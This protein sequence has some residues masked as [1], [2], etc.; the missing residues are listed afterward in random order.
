MRKLERVK[1]T[2]RFSLCSSSRRGLRRHRHM[3]RKAPIN[4]WKPPAQMIWVNYGGGTNREG[5][6]FDP[7]DYGVDNMWVVLSTHK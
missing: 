1:L 4:V 7:K 2:W 3:T 5:H 6:D